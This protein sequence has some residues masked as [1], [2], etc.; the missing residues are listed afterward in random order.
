MI[1]N[2][3]FVATKRAELMQVQ[4]KVQEARSTHAIKQ[5]ES[6][7]ALKSALQENQSKKMDV[8]SEVKA[9]RYAMGDLENE[10]SRKQDAVKINERE[11]VRLREEY[12]NVH[13]RKMEALDEHLL[14]C[15]TCK[16]VYE[17]EQQEQIKEAYQEE[18]KTFNAQK[19]SRLESVSQK[20]KALADKNKTLTAEIELLDARQDSAQ[21]QL[22][23]LQIDM[24]ILS[25]EFTEIDHQI[26]FAKQSAE[27]FESSK[28]H[29]AL[30]VE[31][32]KIQ[33]EI[34][35]EQ[36]QAAVALYTSAWI[37]I[38]SQRVDTAAAVALYT[39]AWIEITHVQPP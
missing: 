1:L 16:R 14:V 7:S 13:S 30:Q 2:G 28:E 33:S 39:S 23:T 24:D 37:E 29:A 9:I 8:S 11:M 35:N 38:K 26:K 17:E 34:E 32:D 3:G 15:H 27:P 25:A 6:L 20:G 5:N 4:A 10:K 18:T 12:T 36:E 19:A 21:K 22:E 31:I